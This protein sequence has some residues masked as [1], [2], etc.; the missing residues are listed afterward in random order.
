MDVDMMMQLPANPAAEAGLQL[1][2]KE[3]SLEAV[4]SAHEPAEVGMLSP[5]ADVVSQLIAPPLQPADEAGP[6]KFDETSMPTAGLA[7][8]DSM[9]TEKIAAG[10]VADVQELVEDYIHRQDLEILFDGSMQC[11]TLPQA[12][13]D[14]ASIQ[15][16]L[17][18]E[19]FDCQAVTDGIVL[20]LRAGNVEGISRSAVSTA[21]RAVLRRG[22]AQRRMSVME[23]LFLPLS[24]AES[25][26]AEAGWTRLATDVFVTNP[27]LAVACL[28]HFIW[29]VKRKSLHMPV[30]NHLM[31]IVY[32][33]HQGGGKTTFVKAFVSP[34]KELATGPVP[35]SDVAD[36]RSGSV[37]RFPAIIVDDIDAIRGQ[38]VPHLKS[39][40]TASGGLRRRKQRTSSTESHDQRATLIG[41]SNLPVGQ[42]IPDDT[43]SRRFAVVP[44]PNGH[45]AR[46]GDV[47]V[48]NA[49]NE[50][51][52]TLLW[53]SVDA[54]AP[55]P[56]DP[57][58]E[59]LAA[60]QTAN[61]PTVRLLNWLRGLDLGS[62]AVLN[63]TTEHGIPSRQLSELFESQ[64]GI[65]KSE[66]W[67]ARTVSATVG[68][69][70]VP[71]GGK[72]ST[73]KVRVWTLKPRP[74]S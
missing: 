41:T 24:E 58:L 50:I 11:R 32:S 64:T 73:G 21:L 29:Q 59:V 4:P 67:F 6:G 61:D 14:P 15:A 47:K 37:F 39:V 16:C 45:P 18:H 48:W 3:A 68:D 30:T 25:L 42:L 7:S 33:P 26:R 10:T 35:L 22:R 56:L 23:P 51:D 28:K 54:F 1:N 31:V 74:T 72:R 49:V 34:L 40:L 70:L 19:T 52:A 63:I 46:G 17:L 55:S 62:E 60:E 12:A 66:N 27:V 57:H 38:A 69:P 9:P 44:F 43:G 8:A 71:F 5:A 65:E 2:H 36:P 20:E 53:R 13:P